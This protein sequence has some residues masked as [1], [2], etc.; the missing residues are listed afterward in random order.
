[1][2]VHL[3]VN[4]DHFL[5][6]TYCYILRKNH[7]SSDLSRIDHSDPAGDARPGEYSAGSH[8][9]QG[10]GHVDG[11]FHGRIRVSRH[12]RRPDFAAGDQTVPQDSDGAV[13]RQAGS[14]ADG[15]C[16]HGWSSNGWSRALGY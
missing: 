14:G 4:A 11:R 12:H 10:A 6:H 9:D 7:R 13:W 16:G 3:S 1:M 8:A 2:D 5:I 15:G